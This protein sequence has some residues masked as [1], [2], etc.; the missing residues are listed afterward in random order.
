MLFYRSCTR[1]AFHNEVSKF[2][3]AEGDREF[4]QG[5]LPVLS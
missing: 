5:R 2:D 3:M 1:S 4:C